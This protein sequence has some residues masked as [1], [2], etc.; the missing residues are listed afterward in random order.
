M[1]R[2]LTINEVIEKAMK[3]HGDRYCYDLVEYKNNKTKVCITC[4]EHG[5]FWQTPHNHIDIKRGCPKCN[6]GV[7]LTQDEANNNIIFRLKNDIILSKPYIHK[8]NRSRLYLKCLKDG[9]EWNTIYNNFVNTETGCPKCSN[10]A[11][12]TQ[13]EVEE[14]IKK[15]CLEED[16]I[17][18]KPLKYNII[19]KT[20]L[21]LLCNK[22]KHKWSTSY[23]NFVNCKTGCSVCKQSH[24]E[25]DI[26]LFLLKD[27]IIFEQQKRFKWLGRKS[28]DFYLP[29][30][31]IAIECQ[32]GQHFN[33]HKR[34][35]GEIGLNT[36]MKR[37]KEKFE[38]C[39]QNNINLIYYS[40]KKLLP[41]EY[42]SFIFTNVEK[43]KEIIN[44]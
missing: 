39:K 36:I 7:R 18:Y 26:F 9:Y 34:Y 16:C 31:N 38:L 14:N 24:L 23:N 19:Q 11:T 29:D 42:H 37:D 20:R 2:R 30:Y 25:K 33:S 1:S 32:G 17:L 10:V 44:I 27:N 35:G 6:G 13:E 40:Y 4:R 15:R 28:L 22:D 3:I 5:I 8:N 43:I 41:K 21:H 12:L